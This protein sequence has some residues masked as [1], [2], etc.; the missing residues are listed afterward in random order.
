M[1]KKRL[2]PAPAPSS[3][4][5]RGLAR[6]PA[7]ARRYPDLRQMLKAA[8]LAAAGGLALS[9]CAD[10]VCASDSLEEAKVHGSDGVE[11]F[12]DL[13]FEA[14]VE[15]LGVATGLTPHPHP[16]M[17]AGLMMPV[18]MPSPPPAPPK[19]EIPEE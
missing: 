5:P 4:R 8:A 17:V 13:E 14:G 11:A 12:V 16:P 1:K 6:A 19:P 15:H 10:P 9:G 3:E 7:G 2:A 18:A